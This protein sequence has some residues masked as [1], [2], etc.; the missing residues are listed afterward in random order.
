MN[1]VSRLSKERE[2]KVQRNLGLVKH[3]VHRY[4][5][6]RG[7]FITWDEIYSAGCFGLMQAIDRYDDSKGVKFSTY[8]YRRILGAIQDEFRWIGRLPPYVQI[9][10]L[11]YGQD[12][13][14]PLVIL[15]A[16]ERTELLLDLI[17]NLQPH[18]QNVLLN[19]YL[20]GKMPVDMGEDFGLTC[21]SISAMKC[22]ALVQIRKDLSTEGCDEVCDVLDIRHTTGQ[23]D[24][25]TDISRSKTCSTSLQK[26][27]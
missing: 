13:R 16:K 6:G 20:K 25:R 24:G 10:A 1:E 21:N 23:T 8:A 2:M 4:I 18:M 15:L 7:D 9:G 11:E 14:T 3:I 26:R 19:V 22:Q 5:S 27:K 17:S 12:R